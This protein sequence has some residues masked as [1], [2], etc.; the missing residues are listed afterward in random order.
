MVWL[1][2]LPIWVLLWSFLVPPE[3][4]NKT[5]TK[6]YMILCSVA[7]I[8]IVGLRS[9]YTGSQDTYLYTTVFSVAKNYPNLIEYLTYADVFDGFFLLSEGGFHIYTW[10]AAQIFPEAQW[11][12]LLTATVIVCCTASFISRNSEDPAISWIV[13]VC[14]GSMTFAMNGMRQALA[15][16][17]CLLSYRYAR[18][19]KL[20]RFLLIVLLAVLF[21]KSAMIF[22]IVYFMRNMKWNAKYI[23][24]LSA[25]VVAFI[26]FADR[27]AFLYDSITDKEY[28]EKEAF[29]S[30]GVITI[31]IYVIAIALLLLFSKRLKE[32]NIF[33]PMALAVLG[34]A[35]YMGRFTSTQIYERISYY[36]VYF[37]ML[38]FPGIFYDIEEKY[39]PL[40]KIGFCLC[41][42]LL[43]AYRINNGAF[44]DF[45]MFWQD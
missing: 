16:S 19:K 24:V 5:N 30:G 43:F 9:R 37:L 8:A 29:K 42:I 17:I 28:A 31:L 6:A 13:F 3:S 26:A 21:H 25:I 45:R 15:M 35:L 34:F 1:I 23:S 40:L 11:F 22:A 27:F 2:S 44:S 10:I 18:E 38:V 12:L 4:K 7:L 20:F 14:L 41:A 36:F 32:P 39:R 33:V